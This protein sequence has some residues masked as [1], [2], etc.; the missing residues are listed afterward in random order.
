ML[1][2][3]FIVSFLSSTI[4]VI[5]GIGG[6]IIIK[7][8]I[9]YFNM[10]EASKASLLSSCSVLS[11]SL[12]TLVHNKISGYSKVNTKIATHLAVGGIFGGIIG[13][14]LLSYLAILKGEN[15]AG[16]LQSSILILLTIITIIFTIK[17]MG[18]NK[19]ISMHINNMLIC[20]I[21]GM[22]LGLL[23]SFIGIGGGP[24]NI[25]ILYF[26]FGMDEKISAEN[27]LYIILFS[28]ISN[29][30]ISIIRNDFA[31]INLFSL[32]AMV[33]GGILGGFLGKLINK[34]INLIIF[35]KL[36]LSVLFIIILISMYNLYN[37]LCNI[38]YVIGN[39][40]FIT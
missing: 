12:Y 21:I 19:I 22:I 30:F 7:P 28:Q 25:I 9:D 20:L 17:N 3:F 27:S 31:K 36:F 13:K 14:T 18:R 37:F 38:F 32:I 39:V 4:G 33:S 40:V 35:Q 24:F 8:V 6:G 15:I 34:K 26:F 5:C 11:M 16:I 10:L 1:I 29:V 23:C 2:I